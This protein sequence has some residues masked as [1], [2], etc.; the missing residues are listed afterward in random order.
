MFDGVLGSPDRSKA[1]AFDA[2]APPTHIPGAMTPEQAVREARS[3]EFRPAYLLLGEESYLARAALRALRESVVQGP[4]AAFNEDRFHA[5]EVAVEAALAAARTLPM[6]APRRFVSLQGV[7]RWEARGSGALDAL[8]EYVSAPS[9]TTVLV[10]VAEKL[11]G[12][13]RLVTLAKKGGFLVDCTARDRR[14][15]PVFV[16]DA[17]RERGHD[18]AS[19]VAQ[20]LVELSNT[21]LGSLVDAVERLSL[22]VG[23]GAA[24]DEDAVAEVVARVRQGTVWQLVDALG[25]ADPGAALAAFDS[26]FDAREGGLRL[27]GGIAWSVRQLAKFGAARQAGAPPEQAARAAGV[28]PFKAAEVDRN[29]RRLGPARMLRWLALLSEADSALK[30]SKRPDRAVVETLIV[31]M[32]RP[33]AVERTIR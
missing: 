32:C 22:Y 2:A 25:R 16:R 10:L 12:Q 31:E 6:M 24:I 7:E 33:D 18:I 1:A 27:L 5:G 11:H 3:G 13:R 26:A 20:L 28:A 23:P 21:D 17:A 30:G 8:A 29:L 9:P 4:T 15:L 14:E 19:D